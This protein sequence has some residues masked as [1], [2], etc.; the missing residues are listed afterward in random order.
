MTDRVR[1]VFEAAG[2]TGALCV[3]EVDG[4]GEFAVEADAPVVAASVSKVQIAL[5]AETWFAEGRLDPRE[6]VVLRAGERTDGPTGLSLLDDDA[7]LSLR[8]L[9]VLMLTI[10]DNPATDELLRRIGTAPVN[11]TAERL[12][13]TSTV[14]DTDLRTMLDTVG[15]DLGRADWA[16]LQHWAPT[17]TPEQHTEADRLLLASRAL[18]PARSPLRTT[19][20][21]M[22]RLLTLIWT[23]RAGPAAACARVRS[24]M[25]R[26]LTR[27]RL[28]SG[29]R[30]PTRVAAKSG[31]LFGVVRNEVGVITLPDGRHYAAAVFT[32]SAPGADDAAIST[33]IGRSAALAVAALTGAA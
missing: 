8:D 14:L 16:D 30:P 1:A 33:A 31:S 23:D 6:R 21:D 25:A 24:V 13:L 17:A 19:P 18:D 15:Q 12:G 32:R 11:T 10:S 3:L 20:R 29:F 4:E 9:V 28:G 7:E 27:H 5:E 22:A 26:Q 2:C